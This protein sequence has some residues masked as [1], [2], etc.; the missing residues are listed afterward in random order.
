MKR[1]LLPGLLLLLLTACGGGDL[2]PCPVTEVNSS[3]DF[4]D[5]H[6]RNLGDRCFE[7]LNG[8]QCNECPSGAQCL[9]GY[10]TGKYLD[11]GTA[12]WLMTSPST[13]CT[14][15]CGDDGDCAGIKFTSFGDTV[16]SETWGCIQDGPS[17]A[18]CGV[19]TDYSSGGSSDICSGCGGAF[20]AGNCIGCPQC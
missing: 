16:T 1:T 6:M 12:T 5:P 15:P 11:I 10:L 18:F 17:G 9:D 13:I 8:F 14:I 2:E 7:E 3:F 19:V 4:F 20:C